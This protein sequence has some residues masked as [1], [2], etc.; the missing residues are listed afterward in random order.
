MKTYPDF[1]KAISDMADEC[2]NNYEHFDQDHAYGIAREV[3]SNS[4]WVAYYGNSLD[5][6]NVVYEHEKTLVNDADAKLEDT[7]GGFLPFDQHLHELCHKILRIAVMR[8]I[9]RRLS[10]SDQQ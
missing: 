3:V 1:H 10:E 9:K 4:V 5:V 6:I 2:M 7:C 8:E